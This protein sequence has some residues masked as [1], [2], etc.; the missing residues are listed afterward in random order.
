MRL[1]FRRFILLLSFIGLSSYGYTHQLPQQILTQAANFNIIHSDIY[2]SGAQIEQWKQY[3]D[4]L[5]LTAIAKQQ[6]IPTIVSYA[7]NSQSKSGAT[8]ECSIYVGVLDGAG[9]C[10]EIDDNDF[11]KSAMAAIGYCHFKENQTQVLIGTNT[12]SL[13]PFFTG[14][15]SFLTTMNETTQGAHHSQYN[16][17]EGIGFHCVDINDLV[18]SS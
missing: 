15:S 16:K 9:M 2:L 5:N 4:T 10:G 8:S 14:P 6:G 17:L 12:K 3:S 11:M 13:I 7:A 18:A 1:Y